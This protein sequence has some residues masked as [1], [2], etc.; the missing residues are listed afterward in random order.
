MTSYKGTREAFA[1]ALLEMAETDDR[2]MFV[3]PD[4]LKAMRATEFGE[5]YPKRYV[6]VGIAEQNAL[7]V[8]AGMASCGL[9]PFIGTYGGFITMRACEQM[10]TF[11]A[12]PNLNVKMIGINGGMV[13]GEREGVTHQS[14]EDLGIVRT[15]PGITV[16]TPCDESQV[17]GAVKAC[18][19]IEGP[20][21]I[22]CGSGR[23]PVVYDRSIPFEFGKI[24]LLKEYGND[25]AVFASGFIMD[26][27]I[28]AVEALR[29]QGINATLVDVST[30]K[31][32][33][34]AGVI[35]IL[36]K[37]GAA[38]TVEDHNIIG[39][40]GS[41]ISETASGSY[42]VPVLRVGIRDVF[43]QSGMPDELLDYYG[44]SEI[45]I[46]DSAKKSHS[47]EKNRV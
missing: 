24:R 42:P 13:G 7:G 37:C 30:L 26:R 4:S 36:K 25:V 14:I 11:I 8:A 32:L 1:K 18:V 22:R 20:V 29:G 23:E 45:S 38:V 47:N 43:P 27:A 46:M 41:A 39:G 2:L 44:I 3:S 35:D 12:Y 31:P 5:T 15:I 28:A 6:E 9:I 16:L 34:D 21:Y 33:D 40:M 17:Y 19:D 10:R